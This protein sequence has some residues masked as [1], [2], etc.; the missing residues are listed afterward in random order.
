MVQFD[1]LVPTWSTLKQLE[2]LLYAVR[3]KEGWKM[4]LHVQIRNGSW[5]VTRRAKHFKLGIVKRK[6]INEWFAMMTPNT[7]RSIKRLKKDKGER[8]NDQDHFVHVRFIG[9]NV[10][11]VSVALDQQTHTS[12]V[13]V[14]PLRRFQ[15][16]ACRLFRG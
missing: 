7:V 11:N 15:G 3:R 10:A 5:D 1:K 14:C 16:T 12:G 2:D 6:Y 13:V 8:N 9:D 4:L